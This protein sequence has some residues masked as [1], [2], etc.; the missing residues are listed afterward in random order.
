MFGRKLNTQDTNIWITSDLH[1]Y[2]KGVL[3]FCPD[4]R[5]FTDLDDM[6]DKIIQEWNSKVSDNDLIFHLGDF[7]FKG[8]DATTEVLSQL[9]GKKVM[10]LGNH[11]KTLRNQFRRGQ[12]G[13]EEICDY[14]EV[15]IDGTKVC[16]SH[17][18]M[19]C[20]NQAGRGAVMLHAHTHSSYQGKGR[21]VDVGYDNWG[22][23]IPIR[24]AIDFCLQRPVYSPDQHK[25]IE[26]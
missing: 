14:M 18:P 6:H 23:I 22:R 15:R 4:T 11:D 16:M 5:P 26:E 2:H 3:H 19:V 1:F 7:S 9:K 25:V 20:F 13:I 8:K 10:I 24:E 21:T 17:F 12:Y